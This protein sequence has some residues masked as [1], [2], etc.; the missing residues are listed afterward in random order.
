M[1]I[2]NESKFTVSFNIIRVIYWQHSMLKTQLH[3][4]HGLNPTATTG[5]FSVRVVS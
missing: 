2:Y 1:D 4:A 3:A 5:R